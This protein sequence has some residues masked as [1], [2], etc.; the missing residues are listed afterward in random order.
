MSFWNKLDYK[1]PSYQYCFGVNI[2]I[3]HYDEKL[4][5][6]H[7]FPIFLFVSP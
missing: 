7:F 2:A 1:E 3:I 4:A 5:L 6:T